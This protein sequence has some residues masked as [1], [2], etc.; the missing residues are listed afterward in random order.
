MRGKCSTI[1]IYPSPLKLCGEVLF[2]CLLVMFFF[3]FSS[4]HLVC[5]TVFIVLNLE[6]LALLC[7]GWDRRTLISAVCLCWAFLV[8]LHLKFHSLLIPFFLM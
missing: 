7:S 2:V 6:Q 8:N 3:K 4:I 5:A 1:E